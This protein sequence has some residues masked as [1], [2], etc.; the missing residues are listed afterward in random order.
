MR[1]LLADDGS[2]YVHLDEKRSHYIRLILDEV[3]GQNSFRREII[4][5]ITV[6]SGF[7]VQAKNWIR[8]HDTVLYY[9]KTSTPLFNKLRQP[10]SQDYIDMLMRTENGI[11]LLMEVH[12]I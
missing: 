5:D 1:E 10:H 4:W 12:D 7:K 11:W 8:G 6:L 9:S 3:F 2:I